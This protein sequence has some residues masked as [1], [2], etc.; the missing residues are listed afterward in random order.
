[1]KNIII[2][3]KKKKP[4]NNFNNN[5]CNYG[6]KQ[7]NNENR[8]IN[9]NIKNKANNNGNNISKKNSYKIKDGKSSKNKLYN[10]RSYVKHASSNLH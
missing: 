1:M 5:N 8:N 4:S 3:Q 2:N 6:I 10:Y 7:V 9:Y